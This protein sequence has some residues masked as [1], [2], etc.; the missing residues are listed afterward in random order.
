M[1]HFTGRDR[2]IVVRAL[3]VAA[4]ALALLH[5]GFGLG[6][7]ALPARWDT[8]LDLATGKEPAETLRKIKAG[9]RTRPFDTVRVIPALADN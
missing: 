4:V 1:R 8:V 9:E 7:P 5:H 6:P 2:H 3:L